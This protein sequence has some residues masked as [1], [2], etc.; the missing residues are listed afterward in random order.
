MSLLLV[1]HRKRLPV[2]LG[3]HN[4]WS[5][6]CSE[7]S[8]GHRQRVRAGMRTG[9]FTGQ[10]RAAHR[11]QPSSAR[12]AT[13]HAAKTNNNAQGRCQTGLA[14]LRHI[15]E[16]TALPVPC[17]GNLSLPMRLSSI[18]PS[19][20]CGAPRWGGVRWTAHVKAQVHSNI[21]GI[22]RTNHCCTRCMFY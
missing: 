17:P 7:D 2:W 13:A 3:H 14:L 15:I 5:G 8:T 20:S 16:C 19:R 10:A 18:V 6:R 21:F 9:L 1:Q 22:M 11:R 12:V 4:R